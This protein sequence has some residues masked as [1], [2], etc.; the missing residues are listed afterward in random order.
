MLMKFGQAHCF[1]SSF[2]TVC[3]INRDASK[4]NRACR[5]NLEPGC[6]NIFNFFLSFSSAISV[7]YEDTRGRFGIANRDIQVGEIL[8]YE[9]PTGAR[10]RKGYE[11]DHCDNVDSITRPKCMTSEKDMPFLTSSLAPLLRKLCVVKARCPCLSNSGNLRTHLRA[12]V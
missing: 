9:S 4:F 11:K 7:K 10:M 6:N 3:R 8:V 12:V 2:V 5:K 1:V